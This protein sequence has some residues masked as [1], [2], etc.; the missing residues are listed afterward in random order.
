MIAW[1][2]AA[3]VTVWNGSL[4]PITQIVIN[5]VTEIALLF[6]LRMSIPFSNKSV[7]L[8]GMKAHFVL[9]NIL[10]QPESSYEMGA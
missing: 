9:G 3:G 4:K 8:L 1:Y 2:L 10:L 5:F 6:V 7:C